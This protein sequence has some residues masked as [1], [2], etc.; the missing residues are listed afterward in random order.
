MTDNSPFLRQWKLLSMMGS[1]P[2]GHGVEELA[3]E[4]SVGIKTI[5][6]DLVMLQ[7]AGFPLDEK[8][9]EH[10]RKLWRL[11]APAPAVPINWEEA[12]SLYLARR[13]LAPL[14]GTLF[15]RS[16]ESAI[17]KIHAGLNPSALRYL[18]RML[19][20]LHTTVPDSERYADKSTC[21]DNLTW[22]IEECRVTLLTY[23]SESSTEPVTREIHPY[24]WVFHRHAT[25]LAAYATAHNEVRLYKADRMHDAHVTDLRFPRPS[26]FDVN[27]YLAGSFGV[28][29]G[30]TLEPTTVRVHFAPAVSRY[31]TESQWHASQKLKPQRDGSLIA[32]FTLTAT[33]E[34]QRW[35]LS[36]GENAVVESPDKLVEEIR[37]T[38]S[39]LAAAYGVDS[40][41]FPVRRRKPR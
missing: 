20:V 15:W 1:Q 22:A 5:R 19:G 16:A 39:Q 9:V 24:A 29:R 23:Q 33:E 28:Y 12:L 38:I 27:Q 2:T 11:T 35:I 37:R 7:N 40:A 8:R 34:I 14:K 32:E 17:A 10:G 6:R 30:N 26:G 18:D 13:F 31:V 36:F 3:R 21:L 25:Y 4:L 41:A